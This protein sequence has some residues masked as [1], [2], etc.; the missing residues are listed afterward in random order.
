MASPTV[1]AWTWTLSW[2]PTKC[3]NAVGIFNLTDIFL[4]KLLKFSDHLDESL[5]CPHSE[6]TQIHL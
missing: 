2:L 1:A 6:P 3:R 5:T 4:L